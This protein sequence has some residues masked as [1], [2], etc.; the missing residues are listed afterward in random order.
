MSLP[1]VEELKLLMKYPSPFPLKDK[2]APYI[3]MLGVLRLFCTTK[4]MAKEHPKMQKLFA[5]QETTK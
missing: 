2:K 1:V 4:E 5:V 3:K